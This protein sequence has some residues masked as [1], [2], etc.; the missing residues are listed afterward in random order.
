M[1]RLVVNVAIEEYLWK[2]NVPFL[3]LWISKE[4]RRKRGLMINGT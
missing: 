1:K 2:S 4:S 3:L